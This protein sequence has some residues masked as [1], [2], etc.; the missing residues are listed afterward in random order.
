MALKKQIFASPKQ[1]CSCCSCISVFQCSV[2]VQRAGA[3]VGVFCAFACL[4]LFF[5][6]CKKSKS[7]QK[8]DQGKKYIEAGRSQDLHHKLLQCIIHSHL[9]SFARTLYELL[10]ALECLCCLMMHHMHYI[11]AERQLVQVCVWHYCYFQ[12]YVLYLEDDAYH[13]PNQVLYT[14]QTT[15]KA[16]E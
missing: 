2:Y 1:F 16:D 13:S 5:Q 3:C 4:F 8:H 11:I 6:E 15:K 7:A 9:P 12:Y 14:D 10:F